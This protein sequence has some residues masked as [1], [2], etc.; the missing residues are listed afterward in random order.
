VAAAG[1]GLALFPLPPG[2][3]VPRPGWQRQCTARTDLAAVMAAAGNVGVGCRASGAVALDLDRHPGEA[4]GVAAFAAA[5]AGHG[6]WPGT[7]TVATPSGLHLYFLAPAWP[8]AN[9]P[10]PW[11][12]TDVRAPGRRTGGYLVGPGSVVGGAVYAVEADV[13]IAPLPGWLAELL[14][15]G[16]PARPGGENRA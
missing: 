12:G 4:D 3:R 14:G 6:G 1:R 2:G 15:G 5:S 9:G 13:P 16:V 7:F 10:G 8:V 11:P